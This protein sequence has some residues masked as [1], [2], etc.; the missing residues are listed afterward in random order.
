MSSLKM[1]DQNQSCDLIQS[2]TYFLI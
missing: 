2:Y 1:R